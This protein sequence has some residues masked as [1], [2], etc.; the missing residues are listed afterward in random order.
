MMSP[1]HY[2]A[3]F[4]P[5]LLQLLLLSSP[6]EAKEGPPHHNLRRSLQTAPFDL[7]TQSIF[8]T[9]A[10]SAQAP[11]SYTGLRDAVTSWNTANPA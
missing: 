8:D 2:T 4:L 11:Y 1:M 10:P 6:A 5:S 7:L 9:L 3:F